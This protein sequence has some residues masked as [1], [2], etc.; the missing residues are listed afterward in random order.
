MRFFRI[1]PLWIK[2]LLEGAC[3]VGRNST[4]AELVD[5]ILADEFFKIAV[6]GSAKVR[7][8][9]SEEGDAANNAG[10]TKVS[11][12]PLP[13][14]VFP[15]EGFLL[16]SPIVRGWQGLE[17]KAWKEGTDV[18]T[19]PLRIDRLAPDIMLCIFNGP[20]AKIEI[21]QPPE[22]MH[23][24]ADNYKKTILRD[25]K[26]AEPGAPFN[27]N[28]EEV[29]KDLLR[30]E[31]SRV[32]N[33]EKLADSLRGLLNKHDLRTTKAEP[34]TSAEFGV[35]MTRSPGRVTITVGKTL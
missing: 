23:F 18:P 9:P 17:M 13:D 3:S 31:N 20:L 14:A 4:E 11:D 16:R 34:L 10:D 6:S 30:D 26:E 33:V 12:L 8:R 27:L 24:G 22:G 5:S 19:P 21:R 32:V 28:D 2:R 7:R 29:V 1:D 35:Q 15:L 25:M